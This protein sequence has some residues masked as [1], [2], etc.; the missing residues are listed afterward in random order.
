MCME[1]SMRCSCGAKEASFNFRDEIMPPEVISRLY[2]PECS[3]EI[4]FNSQKMIADNGWV[5]EYDMEVARFS[6]LKSPHLLKEELTPEFIFDEGFATWR[7][8]YPG[9][10]VDSARE[11]EEITRLAK[12]DPKAYIERIKTWGIERMERLRKEGWRKANERQRV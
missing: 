7:G 1:Y 2:C 9:D 8:I 4:A 3:K 5:I 6:A 12:I 11:R 10:H